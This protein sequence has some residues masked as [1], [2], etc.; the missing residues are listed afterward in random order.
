VNKSVQGVGL[1][2][3]GTD[4]GVGKTYVGA[5]LLHALAQSGLRTAAMKPVATGCDSTPLGLRNGDALT[6]QQAATTRHAYELVNPY[7]FCPA[8]APHIAAA[9]AGVRIDVEHIA[10]IAERLAQQ[11]DCLIVEGVGGWRVPLNGRE[12]VKD[13]AARLGYPVLVVVGLRLGC[14]NHALLTV[15]AVKDDGVPFFGWIANAVDAA[16]DT[17]EA[18][19]DAVSTHFGTQPLATLR[20]D[21]TGGPEPAGLRMKLLAW[22]L[23]QLAYR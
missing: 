8:I 18:T 19:V 10:K 13:L 15:D 2:I 22:R 7:A 16:Y 3:T 11:C 21:P 5:A 1:F 17:V 23:A 6:L 12:H 9:S 14:I 4:T 20:W